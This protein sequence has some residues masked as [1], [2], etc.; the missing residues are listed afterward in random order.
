MSRKPENTMTAQHL[1]A[2]CF[3]APLAAVAMVLCSI[4]GQVLPAEASGPI[5]LTGIQATYSLAVALTSGTSIQVQNIPAD[6]R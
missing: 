1:F 3:R 6:G 4:P 5:V 2:R